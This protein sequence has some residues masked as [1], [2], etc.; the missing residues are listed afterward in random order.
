MVGGAELRLRYGLAGGYSPG[1][2]AALAFDTPGGIAKHDRLALTIRGERPMR[3]S[4]QL[5]IG[6]AGDRWSRSIYVAPA[7][8]DRTIFFDEFLPHGDTRTPRPPLDQ[9]RSILFVLDATNFKA[10]D[11]GRMW[12]KRAE[13]QR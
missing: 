12:I 7:H 4:I 9:I 3:I 11:S 1:R 8:E 13:L 2:V 5:R 10:G 6:D